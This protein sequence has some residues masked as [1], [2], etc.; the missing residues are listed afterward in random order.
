MWV[1]WAFDGGASSLRRLSGCCAGGRGSPAVSNKEDSQDDITPAP[2]CLGASVRRC[3]D[4]SVPSR[5]QDS[6]HRSTGTIPSTTDDVCSSRPSSAPRSRLPL[7]TCDHPSTPAFQFQGRSIHPIPGHHYIGEQGSIDVHRNGM[8]MFSPHLHPR[9]DRS[10]SAPT[11]NASTRHP[12]RLSLLARTLGGVSIL[13]RH[14]LPYSEL[15]SHAHPPDLPRPN[16][17]K[18]DQDARARWPRLARPPTH[19]HGHDLVP[20]FLRRSM[21]GFPPSCMIC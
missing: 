20:A 15:P 19:W 6:C 9:R 2:R 21:V 11:S 13:P 17:D 16:P 4:V 3:L 18:K 5:V 8:L 1:A 10:R 14:G 12:S 7:P